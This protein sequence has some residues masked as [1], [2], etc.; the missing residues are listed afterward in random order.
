MYPLLIAMSLQQLPQIKSRNQ[1]ASLICGLSSTH[2]PSHESISAKNKIMLMTD[3]SASKTPW[4]A[5]ALDVIEGMKELNAGWDSY[6]A[7]PP[8]MLALHYATEFLYALFSSDIEPARIAPSVVGGVGITVKNAAR[9]VYV[10]FYNDGMTHALYAKK[11]QEPFSYPVRTE[12]NGFRSLTA[13]IQQ[14]LHA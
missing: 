3:R 4:I 10:E 12:N 6:S 9:K 5:R 14:H 7:E 11:G 13:E 8:S 2:F 1:Y